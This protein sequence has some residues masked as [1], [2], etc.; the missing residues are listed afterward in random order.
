M[1]TYKMTQ[2]E[3]LKVILFAVGFTFL[4][5]RLFYHSIWGCIWFPVFMVLVY[6]KGKMEYYHKKKAELEEQFMHGMR[7]LNNSLQAGLS[8]EN[9]WKEVQREILLLY[10][11]NSV[12]YQELKEMNGSVALN[13]P[14][15]KLFLDLAY[16][17][18]LEDAIGFA[19][20]FHYGKRLG[21]NWKHI[22]DTVV[23]RMGD[24]YDGKKEIE[25]MIAEKKM[26]QTIMNILPLAILLFLQMSAWE[27]LSVLYHNWMGVIAMSICL[28]G[29][30]VSI[31]IS[32][33]ILHIEV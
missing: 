8:M 23:N 6:Q 16:R 22:I 15:E 26:E 32:E 9:A 1:K 12:F 3:F 4:A 28:A 27:Y 13:I 14:I 25:V 18:A 10:G 29:Y 31:V 24:K 30:L 20:V 5:A 7:V 11:E 2:A 33:K 19:E 17:L 21:G